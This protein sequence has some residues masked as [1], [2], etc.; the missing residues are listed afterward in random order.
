MEHTFLTSKQ[1][2][3]CDSTKTLLHTFVSFAEYAK[4]ISL[5]W[6]QS[7][8]KSNTNPAVCYPDTLLTTLKNE[9]N[10]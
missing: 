10:A 6:S 8:G 1:F 7:N 3:R 4:S 2:I 5:D 9:L